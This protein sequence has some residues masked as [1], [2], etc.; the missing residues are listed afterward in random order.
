MMAM[1]DEFIIAE[2]LTNS[3]F[4]FWSSYIDMVELLLL[5]TRATREGN[6]KLHLLSVRS[7]LPWH[8]ANNR[9]NY[10]QYLS[11]Y[12]VEMRD[13]SKTHPDVHEH[14]LAG[15]FCVQRQEEH[16]FAQVECDITIEQTF[17]RDSKTKG[18]LTSF[19]QHKGAVHRWILPQPARAAIAKECKAMSG[20][21][22]EA[23]IRRELDQSRISRDEHDVQNVLSTITSMV[24]LFSDKDLSLL[25]L[26]S[27]VVAEAVAADLLAA[28]DEG[29]KLF[30]EF[31][32]TRLQSYS[33]KFSETL[34][35]R[36]VLTFGTVRKVTKAAGREITMKAGNK[37]F[38]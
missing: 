1:F 23:R 7:M 37:L 33:V 9:T 15:E 5:F 27:V 32:S 11:A 2:G 4:A 28:K 20:Q 26:S 36:K 30:L 21:S 29:E 24:N 13:L 34:K 10:C 8:F 31:V 18:G 22:Q 3:N 14:F 16:G 35:K 17:N 12:Y 25:Q 6:W 19:T 38:A